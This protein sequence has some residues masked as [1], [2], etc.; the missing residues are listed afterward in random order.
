MSLFPPLPSHSLP[1]YNICPG[2]LDIYTRRYIYIYGL[3]I[4]HKPEF[5]LHH[6]ISD[7]CIHTKC[8]FIFSIPVICR[9]SFQ[10]GCI[11]HHGPGVTK[12]AL[13]TLIR[14][15]SLNEN[16]S[17]ASLAVLSSHSTVFLAALPISLADIFTTSPTAAYSCREAFPGRGVGREGQGGGGRS[18]QVQTLTSWWFSELTKL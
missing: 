6:R 1:A 4:R 2:G 8:I 7:I 10:R 15:A 16:A 5:A 13:R 12:H 9:D 14:M 3:Y 11:V 18:S 17:S